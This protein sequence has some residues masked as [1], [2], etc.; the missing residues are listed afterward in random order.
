ML[1]RDTTAIVVASGNHKQFEEWL[2]RSWPQLVGARLILVPYGKEQKNICSVAPKDTTICL[3]DG[4]TS[5][6]ANRNTALN[7]LAT[8]SPPE[9]VAFLDDDTFIDFGWLDEM[10]D[11]ASKYS[12]VDSFASE[13]R[14]DGTQEIQACGHLLCEAAPHD[15]LPVKVEQGIR[16]LC[17]CGNAAVVRWSA[18]QRIKEIDPMIWDPRFSQ[19]QTCFDF[20]LK[21][22]LVGGRTHLAPR[23]TAAHRGYKS[24]DDVAKAQVW[25]IHTLGQLRSRVLL[26]RKFLPEELRQS[27]NEQLAWRVENKWR[28]SGYPGYEPWLSG[29][30]VAKVWTAAKEE[31]D[32]LWLKSPGESWIQIMAQ[33][34]DKATI[35]GLR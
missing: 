9:L 30:D 2:R 28:L 7:H 11:A 3:P 23:A 20:G 4:D 32:K 29:D 6:E 16:P 31:A 25:G 14:T 24:L 17:P 19:W 26:Y 8:S 35:W 5:L 15:L 34:E 33:R 13:V 22:V 27:A 1:E 12:T 21:L 10:L 18:I